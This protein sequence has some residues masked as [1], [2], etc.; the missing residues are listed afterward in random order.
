MKAICYGLT[1]LAGMIV[2]AQT[3]QAQVIISGHK[4]LNMQ[5]S[6]GVC[7]PT[8]STAYLNIGD[9]TRML[10]QEN[11]TVGT[12]AAAPD[13]VSNAPFS[14]GSTFGLTLEAIGNLT[15]NHMISDTGL[16]PVQLIYNASGGG[17]MLSF[18]PTATARLT[19]A[20]LSAPLSINGQA[21]TL[22]N[23]LAAL[24][25]YI[26]DN[27]AGDYALAA[28]YNATHDGKYTHS[29]IP[30]PFQGNFE[31][32]GNTISRLHVVESQEGSQGSGLF[33]QT[34]QTANIENLRLTSTKLQINGNS[35]VGGLVDDNQGTLFSNSFDGDIGLVVSS[36]DYCYIGGLVGI[37]EGEITYSHAGGSV[38]VSTNTGTYSICY[39]GGLVGQAT[40][41][42]SVQYSYALSSV[43]ATV[44][45]LGAAL[46]GG[47]IGEFVSSNHPIDHTFATG[48][49]TLN[50]GG[51]GG[52]L[53]GYN[54]G[55]GTLSNSSASGSV[56]AN[57]DGSE[58]LGGLM[59]A[60]DSG[61]TVDATVATGAV[62]GGPN[63]FCG[64]A[65]GFANT[66]VN[67]S[68][69]Y[70]TVNVGTGGFFLVGGFVGDV[71]SGTSFSNDGWD[72]T[73]SNIK[74]PSKGAGNIAWYPGITGFN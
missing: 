47:L 67:D 39:A 22:V 53:I 4:T 63:C 11:V 24:A 25:R 38:S 58:Y 36:G 16:G 55:N 51:D 35:V 64:G 73:T 44:Q 46:T 59:G 61:G 17:G 6:G 48:A 74:D 52:G 71:N 23:T 15:I 49:V 18:G 65:I 19:F 42:G 57:G 69:S 29:P 2:I 41:D 66:T 27:P 3:A 8:A 54:S 12:N 43:T 72:M 56:T 68:V 70:G 30:T 40:N 31:G 62:S 1:A 9:L 33:K 37:N 10:A 13:I 26:A 5:C 7:A 32:L 28:G 21:Y 14:W 60:T 34:T 20:N 45:Q 50:G